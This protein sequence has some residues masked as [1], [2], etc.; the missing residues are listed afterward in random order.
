MS[1]RSRIGVLVVLAIALCPAGIARA[2]RTFTEDFTT[3]AFQDPGPTSAVWDTVTA[4]VRQVPFVPSTAGTIALPGAAQVVRVRDGL[5]YIGTA[6]SGLQI[7][8]VRDPAAP[9]FVG[10]YATYGNVVDL[11]FVGKIAILAVGSGDLVTVDV[12]DPAAPVLNL[13]VSTPGTTRGV[14][15]DGL[16]VFV[17][18]G[19]AGL[20]VFSIASGTS[21]TYT[22]TAEVLDVV[23]DGDVAYLA[24]SDGRV[25]AVDVTDPL[26]ATLMGSISVGGRVEA[27]AL[28]GN[29][30]YVAAGTSGLQVV[31]VTHPASM[32]LRGSLAL[33]GN[34]VDVAVSSDVAFVAAQSGGVHQVDISDPSLPVETT[35][36]PASDSAQGIFPLLHH[37]LIA[38][39]N[40]GVVLRQ[41]AKDLGVMSIGSLPGLNLQLPLDLQIRGDFAYLIDGADFLVIDLSDPTAP[42]VARTVTISGTPYDFDIGGDHAYVDTSPG[43]VLL[44]LDIS[45]PSNP[46]PVGSLTKSTVSRASRVEGNRLYQVSVKGGGLSAGGW[47]SIFDISTPNLPTTVV[48]TLL[49]PG[50]FT[51]EAIDVEGD[52]AYIAAGNDGLMVVNVN[53]PTAPSVVATH[54]VTTGAITDVV[55]EGNHAYCAASSGGLVIYDLVTGSEVGSWAISFSYTRIQK[56]A[57]RVFLTGNFSETR[58][59]DVADPTAPVSLLATGSLKGDM[60]ALD[61]TR[62]FVMDRFGST[63]TSVDLVNPYW[64]PTMN[65]ARSI[66]FNGNDGTVAAFRLQFSG[67]GIPRLNVS[68]TGFP[69]G[70]YLTS[71][72]SGFQFL[73]APG[74]ALIWDA[75]LPVTTS[76]PSTLNSITIDWLIQEPVITAIHDVPNDQGGWARLVFLPS[77]YDRTDTGS[78]PPIAGYNIHRRIDAAAVLKAVQGEGEALSANEAEHLLKGSSRSAE[79]GEL[80]R[81]GGRVFV[82]APAATADTPL[83]ADPASTAAGTSAKPAAR[84]AFPAGVWEVVATVYATQSAEYTVLVPTL[85]DSSATASPTVYFVSAHS[86]TPSLFYGS[87]P[88][89]GFSVDNLVPV[90]PTGFAVHYSI[91]GNQLSWNASPEPDFQYF[92]VYRGT[93]PDFVADA[94][95]VVAQLV[96]HSW[97]DAIADPFNWFYKVSAVDAAGN[98]SSAVAPAIATD[99]PSA[100]AVTTLALHRNVPNPFN[101]RTTLAFDLPHAGAV[102]LEIFNVAGRRVRT[103]VDEKLSAGR[104]TRTW[105]GTDDSGRAVA[106]GVFFYRLIS[107]DGVRNGKMDLVR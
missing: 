82:R 92:K 84:A 80:L 18:D 59:L 81:Y 16:H 89:S 29:S 93:S 41:W 95:T 17:A 107:V 98:E 102:R 13:V 48:D 10:S 39:G 20:F 50:G 9:V 71:P 26:N 12:S 38:D 44:V 2:Q 63:F 35:T 25:E 51:F 15:V 30:L 53:D 61:G 69:S 72:T 90:A 1:T 52:L 14:A 21:G 104:Y 94:T 101:P 87:L 40:T 42:S 91:A 62:F 45:N 47:L 46:F 54:P 49:N 64:D 58:I 85:A 6:G 78:Y 57:D 19:T 34:C 11:T 27:L 22:P 8:D 3:T 55:V 23:V 97:L 76:I 7:F 67:A 74:P 33:S 99:T 4:E 66:P 56:V 43:G 37:L 68:A 88:D 83:P 103:L 32:A 36:H 100:G 24:L 106:S 105:N 60:T 28:S 79:W 65:R 77:G 96:G 31:Q 70:D 86:T 5:A 75:I 73:A